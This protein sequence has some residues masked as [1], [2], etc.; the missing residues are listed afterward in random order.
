MSGGGGQ[1]ASVAFFVPVFLFDLIQFL[2]LFVVFEQIEKLCFCWERLLRWNP[3]NW[4]EMIWKIRSG[5]LTLE[6]LKFIAKQ[7][8]DL[9]AFC[10]YV[11]YTLVTSE[12][13]FREGT[14]M[15]WEYV[16][17]PRKARLLSRWSGVTSTEDLIIVFMSK[18]LAV[19]GNQDNLFVK[20]L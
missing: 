14:T 19:R 16:I 13:S 15:D 9:M 3:R 20:D 6:A 1:N 2:K 5:V 17:K 12:G 10:L 18:L 8:Q 7:P 4:Q 11:S